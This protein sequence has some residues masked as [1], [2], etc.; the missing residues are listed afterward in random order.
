[1]GNIR[2]GDVFRPI[3]RDREYLMDY[4]SCY[5]EQN[6][7][8]LVKLNPE[9]SYQQLEEAKETLELSLFFLA[10]KE[11]DIIVSFR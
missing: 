8:F 3:A 2:S 9:F 1:M 10:S 4:N 7:L 5:F 6:V 11:K